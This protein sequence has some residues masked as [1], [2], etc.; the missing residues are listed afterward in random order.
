MRNGAQMS[1]FK[2]LLNRIYFIDRKIRSGE[3]PNSK[4][5]AEEWEVSERTIK[6]D[7]EWMRSMQNAPIEYSSEQRG[8]YY[9]EQ[10]YNLPAMEVSESELFAMSLASEVLKQYKN[11]PMYTNLKAMFEKIARF[12]PDKIS[13]DLSWLDSR[14]TLSEDAAPL[15]DAE[16]WQTVFQALRSGRRIKFLYKSPANKE[17]TKRV[18]EPYHAVSRNGEW[19]VLGYDHTRGAVRNFALSRIQSVET[20]REQFT[21]PADFDA[22]EFIDEHF[23]VFSSNNYFQVKIR[24]S[25]KIAP[26]LQERTWHK[27]QEI[28]ELADGSIDLE[29]QTNQLYPL[30]RWVLGFGKHA[31]V[32]APNELIEAVKEEVQGAY[33]HYFT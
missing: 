10:N 14:F 27:S 16:I 21:I 30:V 17:Q 29:F 15:I 5:L 4:T 25:S 23:G 18:F 12:L 9:S 3:Y 28:T 8:Y 33:N 26:Y 6:R 22:K 11:A 19:Y 24:C 32:L 13:I 2:P 1:K 31:Q 20:L 7:I